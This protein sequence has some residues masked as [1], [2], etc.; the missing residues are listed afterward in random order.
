MSY[1][2]VKYPKFTSKCHN[3]QIQKEVII[4]YKN[5]TKQKILQIQFV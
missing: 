2:K 5:H 4:D 1:T 3:S